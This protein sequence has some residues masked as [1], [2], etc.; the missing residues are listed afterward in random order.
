MSVQ[1]TSMLENIHLSLPY[2]PKTA[3]EEYEKCCFIMTA[4]GREMSLKKSVI[5][6]SPSN[7]AEGEAY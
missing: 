7:A 5:K 3:A 2:S 4:S 6:Y 1:P